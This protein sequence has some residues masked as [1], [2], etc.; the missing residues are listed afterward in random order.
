MAT[1]IK[2]KNQSLVAALQIV[3][4]TLVTAPNKVDIRAWLV[5]GKTIGTQ[6]L[7]N[8]CTDDTNTDDMIQGD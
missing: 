1:K 5:A 8:E 3:A 4:S 6:L 7:R 2:T